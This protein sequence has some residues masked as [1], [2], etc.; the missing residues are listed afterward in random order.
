VL[1]CSDFADRLYDEDCRRALAHRGPVPALP[2]DIA[3][4]C[5]SC[6]ACR[7][8]WAEAAEDLA[9]LPALL[10]EPAPAAL[11]ARVRRDLGVLA[12]ARQAGPPRLGLDW[13]AAFTWA[14]L[15]AA[16]AIV[17]AGHLPAGLAHL[18]PA[19]LPFPPSALSLPTLP[20]LPSAGGAIVAPHATLLASMAPL[21]LLGAAVAFGASAVRQA[22]RD[23]LS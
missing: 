18:L 20:T 15:G 9:T 10:A 13:T 2:A 14:A 5:A 4:H 8:L 3:L 16:A 12:A 22:V 23:A 1:T 11:A 7:R 21:A 17:A 6:A 19:Y